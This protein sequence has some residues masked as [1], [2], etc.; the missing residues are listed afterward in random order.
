MTIKSPNQFTQE[1]VSLFL[2][3]IGLGGK[4]QA[5]QENSIDGTMLVTLTDQDLTSLLGLTVLQARKFQN[6]LQFSTHLAN[7]SI[8]DQRTKELEVQNQALQRE[9]DDLKAMVKALQEP[10]STSKAKSTSKPPPSKTTN[11][12]SQ[13]PYVSNQNANPNTTYTT[14][15]TTTQSAYPPSTAPTTYDPYAPPPPSSNTGKKVVRGAA[16]G[17]AK[18]AL[19]GVIGGAIT[20][21]AGKGAAVG[22]A[23]GGTGGAMRGFGQRN[24]QP[25]YYY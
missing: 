18:G 4:V 10:L 17:A 21:H 15:T 1:E 12:S 8:T 14:T 6:S 23:V 2:V 13:Q 25:T 19:L 20:G 11:T 5:F 24:K 22:A 16:G 7:G 3:A 9:V